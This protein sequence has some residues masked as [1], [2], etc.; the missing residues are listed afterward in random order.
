M[1]LTAQHCQSL[2]KGSPALSDEEEQSLLPQVPGWD[3]KDK[4]IVRTYEF[5]SYWAGLG[6]VNAVAWIAQSENHHPDIVLLYKKVTVTFSTHSVGGLSLNDF[7][8]AA[9]ANALVA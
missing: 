4:T 7:I 6:F 1:E 9:K 3:L 8:C 2:P 5:D